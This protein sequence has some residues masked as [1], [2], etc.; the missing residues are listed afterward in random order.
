MRAANN[1]NLSAIRR[2]AFYGT[3]ERPCSY[4]PE[5]A[6]RTLFADPHVILDNHLYSQLLLYGFRRS[7]SHIYRPSCPTCEACIPVRVPVAKFRPNR[8]Q[9]RAWQFNNDIVAQFVEPG[10]H[11]DH[12]ELYQKYIAQR[13]AGGGMDSPDPERYVE[14]LLSDWSDTRFVEFRYGTSLL[15]VAVI[16]VVASGWSAVYTFFDPN[17]DRRGLGTYAILWEIEQARQSGLPWLYLGYWI[18]ECTKMNY[19]ARFQPLEKFR[20]GVWT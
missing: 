14:F 10:F 5:R 7:G 3:P 6:A 13:H 11:A 19:K 1:D 8:A 20:D 2:L 9:R 16:D 4:L 17:Q 12:F 18:D 15:A